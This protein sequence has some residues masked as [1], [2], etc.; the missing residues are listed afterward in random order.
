[1]KLTD[2]RALHENA[3]RYLQK[4]HADFGPDDLVKDLTVAQQQI[5]EIAKALALDCKLIAE[6][7]GEELKY[8]FYN[9]PTAA[10]GQKSESGT[11]SEEE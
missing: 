6:A 2:A 9:A 4:F 8:M 1:M 5:I 3:K 7:R 10:Q 11:G